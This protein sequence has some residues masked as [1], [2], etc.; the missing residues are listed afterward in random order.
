MGHVSNSN[1][2]QSD[3]CEKKVVTDDRYPMFITSKPV[4]RYI[5]KW[6]IWI[7]MTKKIEECGHTHLRWQTLEKNR[8][9][10]SPKAKSLTQV[11]NPAVCMDNSCPSLNVEHD[12][13]A[14]IY[15][16]QWISHVSVLVQRVASCHNSRGERLPNTLTWSHEKSCKPLDEDL[17]PWIGGSAYKGNPPNTQESTDQR[18]IRWSRTHM[19]MMIRN[20]SMK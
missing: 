9:G 18:K 12:Q 4:K 2:N 8:N 15:N 20:R 3:S 14:Q 10:Q 1:V 7:G 16:C 11:G 6:F 17:I 13:I 19:K 5:Y